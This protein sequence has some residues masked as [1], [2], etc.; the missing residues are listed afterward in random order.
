MM[1]IVAFGILE[2]GTFESILQFPGR[3]AGSSCHPGEVDAAVFIYT[4]GKGS[5]CFVVQRACV[6]VH[7]IGIRETINFFNLI[8]KI[9]Q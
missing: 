3:K 5:C 6:F 2:D 4:A 9:R 1:E 7:R 8:P